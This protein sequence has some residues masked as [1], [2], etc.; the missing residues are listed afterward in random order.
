MVAITES[1][2]NLVERFYF[3]EQDYEQS[4]L[5]AR[6]AVCYLNAARNE[7]QTAAATRLD[8]DMTK[9]SSM[10]GHGIL[11]SSHSRNEHDF[12]EFVE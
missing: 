12:L 6:F 2:T 11:S 7:N 9:I 8:G 4:I 3:I 10:H 5:V 1:S